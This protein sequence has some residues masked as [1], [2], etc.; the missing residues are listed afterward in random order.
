[1][2]M[3]ARRAHRY[4]VSVPDILGGEPTIE[5]TRVSVRA[6]AEKWRLGMTPEQISIAIP[7]L[8]L[9]QVFD[10]LSYFSDNQVEIMGYIETNKAAWKLGE[11]QQRT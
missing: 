8:T 10:A 1:M 5:G 6:V 4:I 7:H 3:N 2:A 9:A 11:A